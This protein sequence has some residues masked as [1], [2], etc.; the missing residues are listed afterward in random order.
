MLN[1]QRVWQMIVLPICFLMVCYVLLMFHVSDLK[2]R[3]YVFAM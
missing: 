3:I 2:Q 1:Y